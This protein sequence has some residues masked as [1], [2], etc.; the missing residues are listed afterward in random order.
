[1]DLN[2]FNETYRNSNQKYNLNVRNISKIYEYLCPALG[3]RSL[4]WKISEFN[5]YY[6]DINNWINSLGL[7]FYDKNL[8]IKLYN[9]YNKSLN[10]KVKYDFGKE[11]S[12]I[13]INNVEYEYTN[14][15][16]FLHDR[17]NLK[18]AI[19][20]IKNYKPCNPE[21]Y[22]AND[23]T[24]TLSFNGRED[25]LVKVE[26]Y[27]NELIKQEKR[28]QLPRITEET[29]NHFYEIE[30]EDQYAYSFFTAW[31]P[32]R[33]FVNKIAK[34]FNVDYELEYH[35]EGNVIGGLVIR[36]N[37]IIRDYYLTYD[38]SCAIIYNE[39][40]DTY[41]YKDEEFDYYSEVVEYITR[42]KFEKDINNKNGITCKILHDQE[43]DEFV[44]HVERYDD[45]LSDVS[46][47]TRY[48][49]FL[50]SEMIKFLKIIQ[51]NFG[52]LRLKVE[53]KMP[54]YM[55]FHALEQDLENA[56]IV[57]YTVEY[58]EDDEL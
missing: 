53:F 16:E 6:K 32:N 21:I 58:L 7:S 55:D 12:T 48:K 3:Q 42:S 40:K 56:M 51:D 1:M 2:L 23:C 39:E 45:S 35:E 8:L 11:K 28:R 33:D 49:G 46:S 31:V 47:I 43:K 37:N 4:N 18:K 10:I 38:E 24:N 19:R 25:D 14:P 17:K 36:E 44:L 54:E 30:M 20:K 5:Y 34:R 26:E 9:I 27:F 15:K 29:H 57:D 41:S 22:M 52:N 50:D 13:T